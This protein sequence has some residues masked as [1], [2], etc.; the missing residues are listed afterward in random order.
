MEE[1]KPWRNRTA[2]ARRYRQSL[3]Y[4]MSLLYQ[5]QLRLREAGETELAD[6][7]DE[8]HSELWFWNT[9]MRYPADSRCMFQAEKPE[10]STTPRRRSFWPRLMRR[11]N[12]VE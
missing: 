10:P 5:A 8:L 7:I 6:G 11:K 3:G 2:R 12:G 9:G 4:R 1:R